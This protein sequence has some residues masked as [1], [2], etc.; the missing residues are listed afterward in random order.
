MVLIGKVEDRWYYESHNMP[1][2]TFT[3]TI[4]GWFDSSPEA[5]DAAAS[6]L[7]MTLDFR[8]VAGGRDPFQEALA[9][10]PMK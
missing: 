7:M 8:P 9:H 3:G 10:R 4:D 5:Q 2:T 1:P 6:R